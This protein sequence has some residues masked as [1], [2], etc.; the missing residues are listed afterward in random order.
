MS[1]R[2]APLVAGLAIAT[3]AWGQQYLIKTI[4]G[5]GTD[6]STGDGGPASKAEVSSPS[7][8]AIDSAGKIYIADGGVHRVRVI[9]ANGNISTLAGTGLAGYTG[10]GTTAATAQLNGPGGVAVDAAGN[11]YIADTGNTVIRMVSGG[12]ISTVA[13]NYTLGPGYS[14]DGT[15]PTNAQL[16]FPTGVAVDSSGNLY[17][18][19]Q[20]NNVIRVVSSGMI[21]TVG[22]GNFKLN[23]P[24]SVAVDAAGNLFIAD[25]DNSRIVE[26]SVK[27]VWSVVAG[28]GNP[29][30]SGDQGP[31]T[32]AELSLPRS[33]AVDAL[34]QLYIC[35]TLNSR[36]RLVSPAG[37]ITTINGNGSAG[38][39]GDGGDALAASLN[40]PRGIALDPAGN[41][42]I[43]DTGNH[44][45][46]EALAVPAISQNAVVN[47]ASFTP[48]LAPG[49]LATVFGQHFATVNTGG[50]AP[51]PATLA[52]VSVS[53]NGQAVPLLYVTPFQ[54]NFQVPWG[55]AAGNATITVAS[56]GLTSSPVTVPV[57]TA[58]PGLFQQASGRAVVQNGADFSLNSPSAPAKVGST[59]IAYLTGAGPVNPAVPDGAATPNSPL[60]SVTSSASATIGTVNAPVSFAGLTP[61]FIGLVQANI[62]VPA[63]LTTGDYPLTVTVNGQASNAATIS[64]TQ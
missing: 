18:A 38:Y 56:N 27:G 34:G 33:V 47:A 59:I 16:A 45:I 7:A 8:I 46:R 5:D 52:G 42:Y 48:Q 21:L 49:A 61:G 3:A 62:V 64:V 12:N 10:D 58:A 63:G 23:H 26:Y 25:T 53:L 55:T 54:A 43:A 1:K 19:D 9:A 4:A 50:S 35:D 60:S 20:G 32:K 13:G 44:R 41:V 51:L 29:G 24:A 40:L 30:F 6:A 28:N 31:A 57:L 22:G 14:G 15:A 11:V 37:I 36:V 2:F 17:I 39:S